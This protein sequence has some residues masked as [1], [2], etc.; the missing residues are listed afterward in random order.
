[1]TSARTWDKEGGATL[2]AQWS[3]AFAISS[4]SGS[5]TGI[6]SSRSVTIHVTG[7]SGNYSYA[8]INSLSGVSHSWN[9]NVL[10]LRKESND[11]SGTVQVRVTDNATG[12][13]AFR[14][15]S[16]STTGGGCVVTGTLITL[17]DGSQV[18]VEMLTGNET[19]LVWDLF[20]GSF[21]HAPI[22]FIY[23]EA[24]KLRDITYLRFS[25]GTEVG[26]TDEHGFW[27]FDLNRY[28]FMDK[29]TADGYIGHWFMKQDTDGHG[30]PVWERVQLIAVTVAEEVNAAWSPL[31]FGH[32]C[33]FANGIL[34]I[35]GEI[36]G[37]V[38]IFEV[39]GENMRFDQEAFARDIETYGLLTYGDLAD[40]IPEIIFDGFNGIYLA[41]SLGKGLIDWDAILRLIDMYSEFLF[42]DPQT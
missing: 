24:E 18:P 16:Y 34:N 31:T 39:D 42:P 12:Y 32:L 20:T 28:V 27:N 29:D 13:T 35:T 25:D 10:T 17:A 21:G 40:L 6:D 1:M 19:L 3:T 36:E 7:G 30:N 26:M 9:N 11:A 5:L 4:V 2:Y 23:S 33:F 8:V 14:N 15:I 37:L 41:V 22:L 38:N